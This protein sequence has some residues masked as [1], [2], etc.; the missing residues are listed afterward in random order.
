MATARVERV[1]RQL[2]QIIDNFYDEDVELAAQASD[3]GNRLINDWHKKYEKCGWGPEEE[4]EM[5]QVRINFFLLFIVK[6]FKFQI[7]EANSFIYIS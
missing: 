6:I 7:L 4:E 3:I 2:H 5:E 1:V